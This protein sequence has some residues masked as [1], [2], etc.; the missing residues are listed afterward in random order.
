[1]LAKITAHTPPF[2][3]KTIRYLRTDQRFIKLITIVMTTI[4]IVIIS[5]ISY[6][7]RDL[8]LSLEWQF[9]PIWLIPTIF[10]MT[11]TNALGAVGWHI[12]V[13]KTT[14]INALRHNLKVWWSSNL[15]R[16]LPGGIWY[17]ASR[18]AMYDTHQVSKRSISA[19]SVLELVVILTSG[20]MVV[21]ITSPFWVIT[22]ENNLLEYDWLLWLLIPCGLA[23]M[24]PKALAWMWRKINKDQTIKLPTYKWYETVGILAFY[25]IIWFLSGPMLYSLINLIYPLSA[26]FIPSL[27]GMWAL[28]NIVATISAFTIGGLGMREVSLAV[29]LSLILP[30]P[31]AIVIVILIRIFLLTGETIFGLISLTL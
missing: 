30:A 23:F 16:R 26:T 13:Y 14:H 2:V 18:T 8:L 15:T 29:L 7:N 24:H 27:I 9:S 12:L 5:Q 20:A 19:T 1:M 31:V 21:L 10:I 3:G 4:T 22:R 11:L 25:C 17:I 28:A 6:T